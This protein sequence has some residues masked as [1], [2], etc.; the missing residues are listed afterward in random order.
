MK[1]LVQSYQSQYPNIM[2]GVLCAVLQFIATYM[3]SIHHQLYV[4]LLQFYLL[5]RCQSLTTFLNIFL[6]PLA[7]FL[8]FFD[9]CGDE[10]YFNDII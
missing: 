2:Q 4:S 5:T 8:G 9:I 7:I 3:D 1:I 10:V 6:K